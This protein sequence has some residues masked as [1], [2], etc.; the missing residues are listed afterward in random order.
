[1]TKKIKSTSDTYQIYIASLSDYNAG[2]LHGEWVE[3]EGLSVD[4]IRERINEILASSPTAK[5]Y[6]EPSEEHAIHDFELGG[7]QISEYEDLETI[8]GVVEALTEYGEA[9]AFYYNDV[10]DLETAT[11]CFEDAYQG[12]Y[13]S[14]LDYAT[15]IFDELYAHGIPENLRR[16]I[17][18]DAFARDLEA[19]GYYI[20]DGHVFRPV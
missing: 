6:G 15:E 4:D 16:Y 8:V 3:L 14:M 1:M 17:D 19:E 7:I 10:D 9:F 12:E 20:A 18:Y 2:I 11:S 5:K 13:E